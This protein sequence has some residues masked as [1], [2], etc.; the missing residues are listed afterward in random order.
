LSL[1]KLDACADFFANHTGAS[2]TKHNSLSVPSS[3]GTFD[4][5]L[6]KQ[7]IGS[8][9]HMFIDSPLQIS[10]IVPI[11]RFPP[12]GAIRFMTSFTTGKISG[13]VNLFLDGVG[14]GTGKI[15]GILLG[16]LL[17]TGKLFGRGNILPV[18]HEIGSGIVVCNPVSRFTVP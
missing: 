13:N 6:G 10:E 15:L 16:V 1:L 14:G 5:L 18:G 2:L 4:A 11:I 7:T 17:L 3:G 8:L 9:L 12:S